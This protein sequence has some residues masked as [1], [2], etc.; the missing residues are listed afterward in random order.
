[1]KGDPEEEVSSLA[2]FFNPDLVSTGARSKQTHLLQP[3]APVRDP[4]TPRVELTSSNEMRPLSEVMRR[5]LMKPNKYDGSVPLETFLRQFEVCAEYNEWTSR[6]KATYLQCSL[7]KG[8]A[9]LL[10]DF[11]ARIRVI[12]RELV[13]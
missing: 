7:E 10:W 13:E 9:Q 6:D 4:G 3:R 11:G 8:P 5:T 12:Y 2:E 1:M